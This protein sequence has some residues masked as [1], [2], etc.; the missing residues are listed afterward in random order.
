[1]KK[2]GIIKALEEFA[3]LDLQEIWDNSGWQIELDVD[4]VKKIMLC[5]S[6][7][8]NVIEQA[9]AAGADLLVA[10]HPLIFPTINNIV[11]FRMIY[12][13]KNNL[14][15][16]S[17]HTNF[18]KA[19]NGTSA[20]LANALGFYDLQKINDFVCVTELCA[21]IK[22]DELVLKVKLVLNLEKMKVF[23][24]SPNK[25]LR[26]IAFCA[27]A[28]GSFVS[29]FEGDVDLFITSDIKFHDVENCR[30]CAVFD[31]GHLESER[32]S[33][34]KLAEILSGCGVEV[35]FANEKTNVIYV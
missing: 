2:E 34:N 33:L 18:D 21:P 11:D 14:Q 5:V 7:T 13:I 20:Y 30:D 1:M 12:A 8:T 24:Y 3:P 23:N 4:E 35:V 17:L 26:K 10:H 9:V 16:Y 29:E 22:I 28:G 25:E 32:P 31:V 27:G 15:I 19:A 6:A